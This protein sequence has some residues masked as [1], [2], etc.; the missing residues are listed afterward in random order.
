MNIRRTASLLYHALFQLSALRG[1]LRALSAALSDAEAA[2]LAS[3]VD[4]AES[5]AA[6][7]LDELEMGRVACH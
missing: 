1:E 3:L 5:C 4:A 2:R 7:L 6:R